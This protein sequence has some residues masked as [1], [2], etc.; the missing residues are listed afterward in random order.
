M[1]FVAHLFHEATVT[2]PEL[3]DISMHI[4]LAKPGYYIKWPISMSNNPFCCIRILKH[5]QKCKLLVIYPLSSGR[6]LGLPVF[7]YFY[8]E[9]FQTYIKIEQHH[10]LP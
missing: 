9:Y 5:K 8:F 10:K 7:K 4:E 1:G 6:S 3:G 2:Y